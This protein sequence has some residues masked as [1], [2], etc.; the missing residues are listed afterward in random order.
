[1]AGKDFRLTWHGDDRGEDAR[2][3]ARLAV[4]RLGIGV[5]STAL[6]NTPVETGT[7]RRSLHVAPPGADHG[8]DFGR[9]QSGQSLIDSVNARQ[10]AERSKG[11]V[12]CQVGSW[13]AY[14]L[15]QELRVAY[16]WSAFER[17]RGNLAGLIEQARRE[18][19]R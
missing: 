16:L 7:L 12:I 19:G 11:D 10:I 2:K 9:A 3:V 13:L 8:G 14:A 5:V 1:M 6:P 15:I 17:T 18:L 4:T